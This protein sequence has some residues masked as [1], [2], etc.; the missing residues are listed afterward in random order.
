[1]RINKSTNGY[2]F[3]LDEDGDKFSIAKQWVLENCQASKYHWLDDIAYCQGEWT[4]CCY[5]YKMGHILEATDSGK[6]FTLNHDEAI[7]FML[8]SAQWTKY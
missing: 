8:A 5:T 7:M 3:H 1:M 2:F 6:F 4:W